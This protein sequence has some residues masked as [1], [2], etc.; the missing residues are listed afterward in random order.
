MSLTLPT[1]P[2][3][4]P[5]AAPPLA[6]Q[7]LTLRRRWRIILAATIIVPALALAIL[8]LSPADYTATGIVLYDPA[9]AATPGDS[10]NIPQNAANEDAVTASQA[11]IIASL[12]AATQIAQAL[13]LAALP[14]FNASLH[15]RHF[16]L[17]PVLGACAGVVALTVA[18]R[19]AVTA[20]N[21]PLS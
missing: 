14:E 6:D 12:P 16:P 7:L 4:A 5:P 3:L 1:L 8:L 21:T 11:E 18:A 20:S 17:K 13:N 2:R 19:A 15:R 9:S 10:D